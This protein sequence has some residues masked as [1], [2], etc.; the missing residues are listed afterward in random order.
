[1]VMV[2]DWKL[3]DSR[4]QAHL[5]ICSNKKHGGCVSTIQAHIV[6]GVR[7]FI[8]IFG[9]VV[10][11]ILRDLP[12]IEPNTSRIAVGWVS[13]YSCLAYVSTERIRKRGWKEVEKRSSGEVV[14]D[15]IHV[16]N[17]MPLQHLGRHILENPYERVIF[18]TQSGEQTV[19][20]KFSDKSLR[21]YQQMQCKPTWPWQKTPQYAASVL[22]KVGWRNDRVRQ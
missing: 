9:L 21:S 8:F 3:G 16:L 5:F 12:G 1:M 20:V 13:M 10:T 15:V 18:D 17:W 6:I 4:R 2:S 14:R 7:I 22:H 19:Y 11:S